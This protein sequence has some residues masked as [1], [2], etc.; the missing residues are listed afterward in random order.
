MQNITT[1]EI[2]ANSTLFEN[3]IHYLD[4]PKVGKC[5][6]VAI[7]GYDQSTKEKYK[8]YKDSTLVSLKPLNGSKQIK[9]MI[10]NDSFWEVETA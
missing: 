7:H 4:V 1:R 3:Y 5:K 6:L 10:D 2:I 9:R 8:G